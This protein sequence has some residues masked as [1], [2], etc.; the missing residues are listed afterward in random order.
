M[1]DIRVDPL[2]SVSEGHRIGDELMDTLKTRYAEIGDVIIHID[3]EDDI[4]SDS[5][6]KLTMQSALEAKIYTVLQRLRNNVDT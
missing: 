5:D 6:S 2:I 3:P 4:A 1:R